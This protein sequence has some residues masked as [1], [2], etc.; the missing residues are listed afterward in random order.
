M[1]AGPSL[2][3]ADFRRE[4]EEAW[5]ELATLVDHAEK[6]GM[7]S[8]GAARLARFPVLYRAALSS[9]SVARSI[10]LDRNLILYLESLCTRAYVLM[11]G[12]RQGVAGTAGRFLGRTFP[13]AVRRF[14]RHLAVAAAF[15]LLG[16]LAGYVLTVRDLDRF[17]AFVPEGL[18]GGRDPSATTEFLRNALYSGPDEKS[19]LVLF[20]S[21]LFTHNSQIGILAFALGFLAG[22]PVFLLLFTNGLSLGAM[23]ALYAERGLSLDFWGWVLPHGV[24][25]L[26]AVAIC[27]AAGLALGQSLVFPGRHRRLDNLARTG[28]EAGALVI[29]SLA[30]FFTA[31]VIEGIFRQTVM[32]VAVRYGL[33]LAAAVLLALWL[34][35][36]G[37]RAGP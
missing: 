24:T 22:I 13:S 32:D 12:T 28:R 36:S 2:R 18:A 37:R 30:L 33:A 16:L 6:G 4:R 7:R 34:S 8:L 29:G 23:A 15:L 9:L 21:F 26:T 10:S 20:A 11:Y 14:R 19:W 5:R 35:R 31:G 25:E 27:G 1:R 3:S 17:Y